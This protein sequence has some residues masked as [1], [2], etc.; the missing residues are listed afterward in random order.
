[1]INDFWTFCKEKLYVWAIVISV[2]LSY[3]LLVGTTVIGVD[4]ESL[5]DYIEGGS[6]IDQDR[7]GEWIA[8]K[9]FPGYALLPWWT[10]V[11][12]LLFLFG[13]VLLWLY[14]VDKKLNCN[15]SK[16]ILTV[17][18]MVFISFP[19]IAKSY[20]FYGNMITMGYVLCLTA[21]ASY[22]AYSMWDTIG[23]K[24]IIILIICLW[25]VFIFD[26]AYI[27]LFCQCVAFFA[28]MKKYISNE[29]IKFYK[30]VKWVL[31]LC[32]IIVMA[33]VFARITIIG[34]QWY[35]HHPANNYTAS[36]IQYDFASIK[37]F[38]DSLQNFW[39]AYTRTVAYRVQ[40]SFGEKIYIISIGI[41]LLCTVYGAISKRD[42]LIIVL[43]AGNIIITFAMHLVT[44]NASLPHRSIV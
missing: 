36:Y 7:V 32:A 18:G 20:I 40:I 41:M 24:Q 1:M 14:A 15:L 13:G 5:W 12:G 37:S 3:G 29:D 8:Q 26:K 30:I 25:G 28:L 34:I 22:M 42:F 35:T 2:I 6:F 19:Y 17:A 21:V 27:L 39:G 38:I 11:I 33:F 4:D 9:I 10:A 43:G 23:I 16:G 44:G 31:V